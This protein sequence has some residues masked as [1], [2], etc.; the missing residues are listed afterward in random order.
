[1]VKFIVDKD[2]SLREITTENY[3]GTKTAQACIELIKNGPK[4]IPAMQIGI[5][6]NSYKKQP[7]TFVVQEQ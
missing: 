3:K 1:M 7:I 5:A 6:V 2:G 4:W